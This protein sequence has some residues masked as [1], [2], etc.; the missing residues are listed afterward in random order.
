MVRDTL[1][2]L[3]ALPRRLL[4]RERQLSEA[5]ELLKAGE[6]FVV[7]GS[8]GTGKTTLVRMALLKVAVP[9]VYVECMHCRTYTCIKRKLDPRR[10]VVLD[11]YS[12]A[13]RTPELVFLVSSLPFK[14]LVVHAG[15]SGEEIK[16]VRVIEMPPYAK[17]EISEILVER[18]VEL[19]LRVGDE[20]VEACAEKG[21]KAGGNVRVALL[22][23]LGY[24]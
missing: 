8:F 3:T 17:E 10:L 20:E 9:H 6:S 13:Q 11:D 18:V 14:V 24:L 7:R 23:L 22:C 21:F 5:V 4:F 1:Q 12:L 15:F 16:G 19:G 2:A